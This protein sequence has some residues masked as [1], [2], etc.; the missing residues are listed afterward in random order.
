MRTFPKMQYYKLKKKLVTDEKSCF[1][2]QCFCFFRKGC[3]NRVSELFAIIN[4]CLNV[5]DK[6]LN[7]K[8]AKI[9]HST[10]N[11]FYKSSS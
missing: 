4:D 10:S 6:K 7:E 8:I 11:H 5:Q 1:K 2:P 3:A 9:K